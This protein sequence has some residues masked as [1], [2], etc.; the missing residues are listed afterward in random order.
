MVY[1]LWSVWNHILFPPRIRY[2]DKRAKKLMRGPCILIANH[3]AHTDGYYLPQ[4][5]PG[6][7]PYTYVTR[8]WYD[9]PRLHWMFSR[10]HYIPVNLA[11]LDTEWLARGSEVL[12]RGGRVIFFP[13]GKLVPQGGPDEFHPG[14]LMLAKKAGVPVIPVALCGEYRHFH[15]KQVLVGMP[16]ELNLNERGRPSLIFRREAEKCR[17]VMAQMLGVPLPELTET[18]APALAGASRQLSS[19]DGEPEP[20]L[21]ERGSLPT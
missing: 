12:A 20:P 7:H 5:L 8:K 21:P 9:K 4:I 18:K 6:K 11:D 1:A 10:L 17:A 19:Y 16:L 3:T 2:T 13:E 14:F 15:R